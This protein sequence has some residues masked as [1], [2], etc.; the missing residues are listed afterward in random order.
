LSIEYTYEIV[1]VDAQARCME[2]VYTAE[3]HP[4]M[5]VGARLP[6]EGEAVETVIAMFAPVRHWQEL[7]TPVVLPEVG[8]TGVITTTV[9]ETPTSNTNTN[10]LIETKLIDV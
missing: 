10:T 6:Y 5:H 3:G 9:T 1:S 7:Q 8:R 2:V 4:T